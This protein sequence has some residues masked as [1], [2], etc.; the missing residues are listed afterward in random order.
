[1]VGNEYLLKVCL[2]CYP[3]ALLS[4]A[5]H[6]YAGSKYYPTQRLSFGVDIPTK[7]IHL[8]NDKIKLIL[9]DISTNSSF[10]PQHPRLPR[11][12]RGASAVVFAFSKSNHRFLKAAIDQYL[13]FRQ[14]IPDGPIVFIG[15][16][17]E[18][19][20][21]THAEGQSLAQE[22]GAE[23]FEMAVNDLQTLDLLLR[24][25][26]RKVLATKHE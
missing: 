26:S 3:D 17:E 14:H 18:H 22:L 1:M 8:N 10:A 19:E 6:S 2:F 13:E 16:F 5:L 21:V 9:A 15:L 12:L 24:S 25:L 23:Y 7:R 11:Y 4:P 20:V